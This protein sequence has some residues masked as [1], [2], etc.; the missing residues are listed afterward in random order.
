MDEKRY[1]VLRDT[2]SGL[3]QSTKGEVK[4]NITTKVTQIAINDD[5][6]DSLFTFTP[7]RKWTQVE[8]LL[9]PQEKNLSLTGLRAPDFALKSLNG[10]QLHLSD[11]RGKVVVID[12]WAT[13]CG[14]CRQELP[15]VNKLR[16]EYADN[17]QFLTVNN[18]DAGKV[19]GFL[20]KNNYGLEVLMDGKKDVQRQ[21]R[22]NAIPTTLIVDRDGVVRQHY[23]GSRSEAELR[24]A[25]ESAM[26]PK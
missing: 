23:V 22:V 3:Q 12:F 4:T 14:P 18:E 15:S 2:Q 19:R 13:W 21:Y 16:T 8:T 6:D 25:I 26:M 7:E 11:Y 17:V 24:K 1:L 10:E 20:Q 5:V 9:L